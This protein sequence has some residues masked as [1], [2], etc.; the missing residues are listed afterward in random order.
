MHSPFIR[1]AYNLCVVCLISIENGDAHFFIQSN[2][3]FS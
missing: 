2:C 3:D 1:N